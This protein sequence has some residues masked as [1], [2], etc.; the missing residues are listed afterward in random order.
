ME[1]PLWF[2]PSNDPQQIYEDPQ[3]INLNQMFLSQDPSYYMDKS[4]KKSNNERQLLLM[5]VRPGKIQKHKRFNGI[6]RNRTGFTCMESLRYS[7]KGYILFENYRYYPEY[8]VT[9]DVKQV[10]EVEEPSEEE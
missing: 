7:T 2:G 6:V 8:L 10:P 5:R 9:F 4:Y 3:N 1:L